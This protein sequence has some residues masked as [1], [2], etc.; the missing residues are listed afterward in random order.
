[1]KNVVL[2]I[3]IIITLSNNVFSQ[4]KKINL[5]IGAGIS[6]QLFCSKDFVIETE[7]NYKINNYF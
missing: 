2:F 6:N 3:V 4:N 5:F 1:M 7:L